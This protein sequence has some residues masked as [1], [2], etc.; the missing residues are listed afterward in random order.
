MVESVSPTF[1]ALAHIF[2]VDETT[3]GAEYVDE[4]A[5]GVVDDTGVNPYLIVEPAVV[6][7][8]YTGMVLTK[9]VCAVMTGVSTIPAAATEYTLVL[10]TMRPV[11]SR[12]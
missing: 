7:D 8:I 3:I 1:S 12:A 6:H 11:S 5:G 4:N 9:L 10:R 2:L